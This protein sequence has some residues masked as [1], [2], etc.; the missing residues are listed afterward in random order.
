MASPGGAVERGT[1]GSK[2]MC[3]M[4]DIGHEAS[5]IKIIDLNIFLTHF[6]DIWNL[7]RSFPVFSGRNKTKLRSSGLTSRALEFK[8][9]SSAQRSL[10]QEGR[11]N[12]P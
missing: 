9:Q 7:S 10:S 2:W 5:T 3:I 1:N 11:K 8:G 6:Q 12:S 4:L